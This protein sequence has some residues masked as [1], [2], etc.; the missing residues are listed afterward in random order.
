MAALG[1]W[2]P[3]V[4][5]GLVCYVPLLLTHRGRVGADTKSYLYLDPG[6]L[7]G[8]AWSMWD[9]NVGLGTVPHQNIGY[10]WPM[11]PFF[12]LAETSGLP[13]WVAQRLWLASILFVAGLGVRY[14]MRSLDQSGPGVAVAMFIYALS[15]YVLT[16]GARISALLLPFC[17]LGWLLGFTVRAA[18]ERTWVHPALFALAVATFGS[19]NATA[20]LLVGLAPALWLPYVTF[21]RRELPLRPALGV[22]ARIGLLSFAA[23]L[24]WIVGLWCQGAFGI[25][26][27]R[28]TETARTVAEASTAPELLRGLG[29]WYFYGGDKLGAWIEPSPAFTQN[30]GLIAVTYALPVIGLLSAAAL[31][32]RDRSFFVLLVVIGLV[33]SVGAHPWDRGAP[34]GRGVQVFVQS[35]AGLAMR[36]LPR[37]VPL[38]T[39]GLAVL[40]GTAVT[41][42]G[43]RARRLEWPAAGAMLILAV[44]ALPPL[45][46]GQMVANNLQRDEV[47]PAYWTEAAA[48]IDATGR[49]DV[50]YG[51]R[52]LELPGSDFAS[53]RWGDTVDPITPGI[54]DRPYAARELIP[55]GTPPSADLLNA[56]DRQIQESV[57]D[58]DALAPLARLMGV[59]QVV[60]RGD[61]A[62]ERYNLVRPRQVF[63]LLEDAPGLGPVTGFGGNDPNVPDPRLPLNDELE[64]GADPD[65]AD[66]PKVGLFAVDGDPS[67]VTA[68]PASSTV[69]LAGSGDGVIAAAAAGLIDGDELLRYSG[70]FSAEG[71]D[72]ASGMRRALSDG[73]AIIVTDTNRRSARR[74]GS[75]HETDGATE[76]AGED[77]L[78]TDP[79]D[80]RLPLFPGADSDAQTVSVHGGVDV[81]AT[82][83]GNEITYTPE[84]RATGALDD[85]PDTA[86]YT[87]AFSDAVGERIEVAYPSVRRTDRIRLVQAERGLQNRWITRVRLRF[88]GDS[89]LDVDLGPPSRT[90]AGQW[91]DIG[92]RRFRD[93]SIE[94]LAT[95]PGEVDSYEDQSGV[96]FAD[97]RLADGDER[98]Q[99]SIRPPVDLLSGLGD[100]ADDHPL[101]FVL[102]RLRSRSSSPLRS[103]EERR[104]VRDLLLPEGREFGLR[105]TARL[106]SAATDAVLDAALGLPSGEEGGVDVASSRRLAGDLSARATA[107]VDGDPD[108][109][110]SPGFLGQDAEWA[111]YRVA[112]PITFDQMDLRV[113][114]DGRHTVPTRLRIVADGETAAVVEVPPIA[115]AAAK[116]ATT[117]VTLDLPRPVTGRDL[118]IEI[119]ASRPVST[120]DWVS[121]GP[122]VMP[123]GIAEWGI[124]GLEAAVPDPLF[125]TGCRRD[126]VA[127][128]GQPVGVRITGATAAALAGEELEVT[129]C[130]AGGLRLPAG[131]SR[132][133]T[134]DGERTGIQ[135]DRL[136]LR[137]AVGGVAD[138]SDGALLE[139]V[140]P[141][142]A[143]VTSRDRWRSTVE[144]GP[145]PE[146]TWLVIGQS[147]NA[148]W[149]ATVDGRDL[150]P[151]VLVDGYSSGFLVPAGDE[152]VTVEVEWWPQRAVLA[153]LG[154]S[155]AAV[156]ACLLLALRP[157]RWRRRARSTAT[158]A[159]ADH[160]RA[161]SVRWIARGHLPPT[162]DLTLL[163]RSPGAAPSWV[164]TVVVAAAAGLVG[165][166]TINPVAG[167]GL[168]AV[169][170]LGLRVGRARPLLALGPT[171]LVA[172]AGAY[173]ILQQVRHGLPA[174]FEW[175]QRLGR[176]HGVAYSGVLL[177]AVTLAVDHLRS[178][179]PTRAPT[180]GDPRPDEA[181]PPP[182]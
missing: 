78:R 64:L 33:I 12:W 56:L 154:L 4:A 51:S 145:R 76:Q 91:L 163:V 8:R 175:P 117:L 123:V 89:T 38:L 98:V 124:D 92:L 90:G 61:L 147:H 122:I 80:N 120:T 99:E 171:V 166:L 125:D 52:V 115:D 44:V 136:T 161:R 31:R 96:G 97:I 94:V 142:S 165:V 104:L 160:R 75:V 81:R 70:S 17:G 101:A 45:W 155:A 62:Y 113:V 16:L 43:Q 111:S 73:G 58:R 130:G 11:G 137:S 129:S 93:L 63:A 146:P 164:T 131:R 53:Y 22:A 134:V 86:W 26:V 102:T 108:T 151:P 47:L 103:D 95:D 25:D 27:L 66:P 105:G 13:D 1:D 118:R 37:A 116:D 46:R 174:G 50:G 179:A 59:G 85:D 177:L 182:P 2:I 139:A 149:R 88:D 157:W 77:P 9:P 141:V 133:T 29:Y 19:T 30:P 106:S 128:D 41:A 158:P 42:L 181:R 40:T 135:L 119:D 173:A 34:L 170:G 69:L 15:P 7:L 162:L 72:G 83:F 5:L 150:G 156:V 71:G 57:L 23:S 144:M 67:I 167:A 48:A 24:W 109:H 3:V 110:W 74:W 180:E 168:A 127:V 178:R 20:L 176:V 55:Y 39:L 121:E 132:L 49:D 100:D 68:K 159:G 60:L 138:L 54:T 112:Q 84:D 28:Y 140:E 148:G 82:S 169:A 153:A 65:L 21:V 126:L 79:S 107:A 35:Q 14:L 87:A 114:A 172:A 6:R 152:A 143:R 18:R 10:L 32:W 36:S